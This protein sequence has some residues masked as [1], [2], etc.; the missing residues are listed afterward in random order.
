LEG[1]RHYNLTSIIENYNGSY[2]RHLQQRILDLKKSAK[3]LI[4]CAITGVA[5]SGKSELAKAYATQCR[6]STNFI[7][8]LDPDLSHNDATQISYQA[9]FAE[10]LFNFHLEI[11]AAYPQETP[12]QIHQRVVGSLWAKIHQFPESMLIFDNAATYVDI[13]KYL[14]TDPDIKNCITGLIV[15]TTQNLYFFDP[16]I[17]NLC[18]NQGL[19]DGGA[20]LVAEIARCPSSEA[21]EMLA[22]RLDYLPLGLR[23]AGQYIQIQKRT[24][25]DFG[26]G[27]YLELMDQHVSPHLGTEAAIYLSI[28]KIKILNPKL[29]RLLEWCVYLDFQK[30]DTTLVFELYRVQESKSVDPKNKDLITQ[31]EFGEMMGQKTYSLMVYE[32]MTKKYYVHRTT[33]TAIRK[34]LKEPIQILREVITAMMQTYGIKEYTEAAVKRSQK[35]MPHLKALY[36][37]V[38][39]NW[40]YRKRLFLE[41]SRLVRTMMISRLD[42][43]RSD[44]LELRR[45]KEYVLEQIKK[46]AL[47]Y[48]SKNALGYT[49][50]ENQKDKEIVLAAV[51]LDGS[52]LVY[53][54]EELQKDR[55][56]V[57]AAVKRHGSALEYAS[58]EV[59]NDRKIVLAAVQRSGWALEFAS[60]ELKRDKDVVLHAVK[61]HGHA[62][63]YA[64]E[65]FQKDQEIV[66]T[67]VQKTGWALLYANEALRNDKEI[68]LAAVKQNGS[69]LEYANEA[70][71]ADKELVLAAVKRSGQV[72]RYASQE[73]KKDK[74]IVL[75]AVVL[76]GSALE[77]ASEELQNDKELVLAAVV[78]NAWVLQYAS[79]ALRNDKAIVFAAVVQSG[80]ALQFANPALQADKELVLAAVQQSGMALQFASPELKK[81]K[82][83]VLAAVVQ[84]GMALLCANEALKNNKELV[85]AAVQQNGYALEFASAELQHNP[86]FVKAAKRLK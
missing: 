85:L 75:A 80:Q 31:V 74:E 69:A 54:S 28:Q 46:A 78:Q 40:E 45:H 51:V 7:W 73:L 72:L 57:L 66:L 33:Q 44:S 61:Q 82:E 38:Y 42:P 29:Y 62:L 81:D 8:R 19:K 26:F 27:K 41:Y 10:L 48:I 11:N 43:M 71:Q 52:T 2:L 67:A 4:Y 83:V 63:R 5:G 65:E 77:Y 36:K 15:V 32:E 13:E 39:L 20:E 84:H 25:S 47:G 1:K 23:I 6:T 37:H 49:S 60:D 86:E 68:V 59:Q 79:E 18:L 35:V 50:E 14:P 21:A 24:D 55:E 34:S 3:P 56:V 76:D 17:Q 30:L 16:G 53:A 12:E 9:A 64:N 22:A 70:L 58:P